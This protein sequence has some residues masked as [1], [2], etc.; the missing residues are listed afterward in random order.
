MFGFVC[1]V[2]SVGLNAGTSSHAVPARIAVWRGYGQI[3][4]GKGLVEQG[5]FRASIVQHTYV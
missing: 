2:K 5:K 1:R 4:R 3:R